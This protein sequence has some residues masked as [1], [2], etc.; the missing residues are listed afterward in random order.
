MGR[1]RWNVRWFVT[2]AAASGIVFP[3]FHPKETG[4]LAPRFEKE[5]CFASETSHAGIIR[6]GFEGIFSAPFVEHPCFNN[7]IETLLREICKPS[8][9]ELFAGIGMGTEKLI[10]LPI[11][12]L[13][14]SVKPRKN[15]L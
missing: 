1:N 14:S 5:S 9:H 11:R 12:W 8:Q 10:Q 2:A 7:Q 13:G 3:C 6:I 15:I 4:E